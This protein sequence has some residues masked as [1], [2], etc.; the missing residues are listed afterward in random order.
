MHLLFN[1]FSTLIFNGKKSLKL[2][3]ISTLLGKDGEGESNWWQ[4]VPS[5][6][7]P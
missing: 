6:L 4:F 1:A 3:L 5:K 7:A 2:L